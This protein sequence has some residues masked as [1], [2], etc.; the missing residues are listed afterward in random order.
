MSNR[1]TATLL[2]LMDG[3]RTKTA[4]AG[5]IVLAATNRPDALDPAL[6]RPGRFDREV[7]IGVPSS[8]ARR[9]IL[10]SLL[11]GTSHSLS[12]D[13]ISEISGELTHGF[14]GADLSLL[15]TAAGIEAI[16]RIEKNAKGS[17]MT[18]LESMMSSIAIGESVENDQT[19]CILRGDFEA[20][21]LKVKPSSLLEIAL[22]VPKVS[23]KDIGGNERIKR[24]IREVIEWPLL[25][26]AAFS[27][28]NITPPRGILLYG[29]PGCSKTLM[30]KAV[31]S[32]RGLNFLAVK[33][34]EIFSKYVGESEKAVHKVFSRARAAAPCVVFFDEID[35]ICVARSESGETSSVNDRVVAQVLAE[36]DGIVPMEGVVVIA[37]TNQP[38]ALDPA[39][40]RPGRIDR[41][42]YVGP[43]DFEARCAIIRIRLGRMSVSDDIDVEE[44]ARLTEGFSG[45]EVV[46]VCQE[47]ATMAMEEDVLALEVRNSHFLDSVSL[48]VPSISKEVI[49]Y[50]QSFDR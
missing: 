33:G 25:N 5:F 15:C 22:E 18:E 30:A 16:R 42:L 40:L 44:I 45:A 24:R 48:I 19:L 29:P 34:P 50:Y 9:E 36:L 43:P 31:S 28:F 37:A 3:S 11:T 41:A 14:V 23:W 35:A 12:S 26:P 46:A 27:R 38:D 4:S 32:S 8:L 17:G 21:L 20:A 1:V 47:A 39:L 13:D 2:T 7:E 6:R 49:E 10:M